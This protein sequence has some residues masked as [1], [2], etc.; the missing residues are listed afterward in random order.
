MLIDTDAIAAMTPEEIDQLEKSC[1]TH[2][3]DAV[4]NSG[5][6]APILMMTN[7]VMRELFDEF[8][9]FRRAVASIHDVEIRPLVTGMTIISREVVH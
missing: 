2:W 8:E 3:S 4:K 5:K 9:Q 7:P 6:T 1:R